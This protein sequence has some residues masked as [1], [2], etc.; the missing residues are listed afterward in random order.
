MKPSHSEFVPIRGARMHV[1]RWG[2]PDAPQIFLLH[3]WLDTSITFQFVVDALQKEWSVLAPDWRGY[4]FSEPRNQNYWMYDDLADLDALLVHYSPERPVRL[5]AHSLG[6]AIAGLYAG[7]RPERVERLV[8][9]E[10]FGP[11]ARTLEEAPERVRA[12][13]DALR[14]PPTGSKHA[15]EAALARRLQQANTRLTEERAAFLAAHI[16]RE[17]PQGGIELAADPWRRVITV[18]PSFPTLDFFR[19]FW[20]RTQAPT[21]WIRST[22]SYYMHFVF[23]NDE[24]RYRERF[25]CLPHGEEALVEEAGHNLHHDQP[26]QVA[27]LIEAFMAPSTAPGGA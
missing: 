3:G 27:A 21:L 2:D 11:P 20:L 25:T 14:E 22:D 9:L 16:A 18:T 19:Q 12:W 4:G 15:D 5:V 13:L 6:G 10:G 26:E 23:G 1:R 8:S 24:A 7:S 17:L